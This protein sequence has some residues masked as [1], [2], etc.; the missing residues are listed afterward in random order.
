MVQTIEKK[1]TLKEFL[2]LPETK[3]AS[4]YIEGE[5]YQKPMPQAKHSRI[6]TKLVIAIENIVSKNQVAS[7]F[8]ELRCTF[9]NRSLVPDLCVLKWAN[10]PRD[11]QG[12]LL[13]K[14]NIA[15]D[16]VIEILSPSQNLT[17]VTKNILFCLKHGCQLGWLIDP[18]DKSIL[19]YYP[20]KVAEYFE[21]ANDKL[22]I[23][24]FMPELNLTVGDIFNW[25]KYSN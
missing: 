1:L 17:K 4:E 20:D 5:I 15:P 10:I 2:Q 16:W 25:L 24:N 11:N 19:V 9:G 6:Q 18:E 21:E 14:I 8:T 13:N 22:P 7:A 23:P 3:P 12:E